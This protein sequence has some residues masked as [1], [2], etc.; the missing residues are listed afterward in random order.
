MRLKK[1]AHVLFSNLRALAN[2]KRG[3]VHFRHQPTH[4]WV[5]PTNHCNLNC[6]MCPTGANKVHIEKGFMELDLFKRIVDEVFPHT[7]SMTLAMG[8]ESFLHPGLFDMIEYAESHQIK[9]SVNTNATL[10]DDAKIKSLLKSG[11]SYISFAFD[12]FSKAAYEQVRRGSDF[13]KTLGN[14]I[15]FLEM[16]K[17]SRLKKPHTVLSMLDMNISEPDENEKRSFLNQFNRLID[18]IHIREV[19][20][21]GNVLKDS[22]DLKFHKYAGK[23]VPCG[24]LWNTLAVAWNGDV[25]PCSYNLNHEYTVG[26]VNKTSLSEIWNSS[27]LSDLR[28]A[29]L[30]GSYLQL[31]PLCDNCTIINTPRFFGVPAG[32]RATLSDSIV[33]F[34]GYGFQIKAISLANL[35]RKGK[36]ASRRIR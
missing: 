28:K 15:N 17:K 32:L 30:N 27:K 21:W 14:I 23:I 12:G 24:R 3:S 35:F 16:K 6:I 18:D 13:E 29:M 19:S 34:L 4:I 31:S 7:S 33:N 25:V 36:F 11:L 1:K 8:G 22:E 26:N 10:L 20:S 2:Y 5:E 9:V